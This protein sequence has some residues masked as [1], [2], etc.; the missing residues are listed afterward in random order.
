MK[1]VLIIVANN[2][3]QD[4]EFSATY[5][6]LQEAN[7]QI[8]I[9]A[10]RKWQC[11]WVFGLRIEAVYSLAEVHG[12]KFEMVVFIGWWWALTQYLHN[13]DYLRIAQEAN[14]LW[15]ICIAPMVVSE[16]GVFNWKIVT[17][18]DD[19]WLQRKFIE[20][21]GWAWQDEPVIRYG[22]IVTANGPEAAEMFGKE[23]VKLLE[24]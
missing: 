10:W 19:E 9:A 21:F 17:S 15:A 3:F 18:R 24:E 5:E 16:S 14:K 22:N 2:W 23:C 8:T 1:T 6:A 20:W 11:V 13:D 12:D 7:A 4:H